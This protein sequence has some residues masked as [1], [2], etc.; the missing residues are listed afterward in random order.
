M[1]YRMNFR[2]NLR[3][4]LGLAKYLFALV[5]VTSANQGMAQ[6]KFTQ[7]RLS[8]F[9]TAVGGTAEDRR[10]PEE[11]A[12][13]RV[14]GLETSF[15]RVKDDPNELEWRWLIKNVSGKSLAGLRFTSLLDS[16]LSAA[17]NTFF[18]E[19]A[20]T[21]FLSA[22]AEHIAADK[23][24]ISELGY[25]SGDLLAR[26]V[27]GNLQNLSAFSLADPDDVAIAHSLLVPE[28]KAGQTVTLTARYAGAAGAGT[29]HADVEGGGEMHFQFYAKLAAAPC[30]GPGCPPD[31]NDPNNPGNPHGGGIVPVPGLSG[32]GLLALVLLLP[33]LTRIRRR[34][35]A[36][37]AV[38]L[39]MILLVGS[40]SVATDA[41]A[42]FDNGDFESK[43]FDGWT[44]I[45]GSNPGLSGNAPFS[46]T[47]INIGG[48]GDAT[49]FSIVD[50]TLDPR[51]PH[52]I[53]ARQ[54][55]LSAK[56][57][58]EVN[59][60]RLNAV[61]QRARVTEADRDPA[62]G[63]LHL[64]FSYAAVL[65]DPAHGP[66]E[67]P[68]FHVQLK[69]L[70]SNVTLYDDF[71]YSN[72]PGRVFFT[73]IYQGSTWRSTPFIDVDILI[74]ETSL[75]QE[76][77][78]RTLAADCSA[79]GH[80]GYV[81]VDAFG[82]LAI[83]PQGS[84]INDLEVRGKPGNIQLTWSDNGAAQYAI[85]RAE[86]ILGPYVRVATTSS[87]HATWLDR[88][89]QAD[90]PYYYSV[91]ALDVDG[92]ET[93][94]SGE[95]AGVAPKHWTVG[96]PLNR[97]PYFTSQPPLSLDLRDRYRYQPLV[98]DADQ[99]TLAFTLHHA[100]LGMTLGSQGLLEW[101]PTAPGIYRVN[102]GVEDGHG[103]VAGQAFAVNVTDGNRAPVITNKPPLRL[104][105]GRAFSHRITAT[106]ADGDALLYSM[107]SQAQGMSIDASGNVH[108]SNPQ[109]GRYP[110][111]L[112]VSD[113]RGLRDRQQ[114][115]VEVE[116]KPHFVSLPVLNGTSGM[117][118][119]YRA[120]A[121]DD[122]GDAVTYALVKGPTGMTVD[123]ATGQV[124]WLSG[125]V[126][127]Y[128]VS[129]Q[130]TDP[131]G[132]TGLQAYRIKVTDT[133]NNAPLFTSSPPTAVAY[134]AVYGY[135]AAATDADGDNLTWSLRTAPAGMTLDPATGKVSWKPGITLAGAFAVEIE[136]ADGRGGSTLQRFVISVAAFGNPPPT[137]SS[138]PSSQVTAGV[139]Y[140]YAVIA[141]D[142][143]SEALT[144]RSSE[145]PSAVQMVGN[146]L[147]WPTTA[148]D[149][150]LHTLAIE[151]MDAAHNKVTQRWQV[152]VVA[153]PTNQPPQIDSTPGLVA[154]VGSPYRYQLS[155]TDPEGDSLTFSLV[156]GP[157]GMLMMP[158]GEVHWT[159][160]A[161][162]TG[163]HSVSVKVLDS[164]GA[165]Q[166]QT[167]SLSVP[168]ATN[169][170]PTIVSA[171]VSRA[172]PGAAY[173]Y[174]VVAQDADGDSLT[175]HLNT[176]PAGMSLSASGLLA[177]STPVSGAHPVALSVSDNRGGTATQS[178]TLQVGGANTS[179]TINSQPVTQGSVGQA[180][181]YAVQASDAQ[182]D[183]LS[184]ALSGAPAGFAVSSSGVISGTAVSEGSYSLKVEVSDGQLSAQQSWTLTVRAAVVA[185]F[186]AT[187]SA[188]PRFVQAGQTAVL[189]LLPTGGK[190]P[191][192]VD[193]FTV[194]GVAVPLDASLKHGFASSVLGRHAVKAV[195][196]DGQGKTVTLVDWFSVVDPADGDNPVAVISAPGD[197]SDISVADVLAPTVIVG[198]ATDS[199]LADY[200]LLISPAGQ[201]DW[202]ELNRSETGVSHGVLGAFDPETIAN[203]LYDIALIVRDLS[204]K[205]SSAK[206]TLAVQGERKT[207]PLA[208]T[209][210]D[211]SFE[212]EGLPLKVRRTYDS[213]KRMQNLDFGY[214][215]SVD[216]QDLWLQT[217][218]VLGRSWVLQQV[219]SGFNR[220]M[221]VTPG[222]SRVASVRLPDGGLEQFEMRAS[223]E[224]VS[225]LQ[226]ASNPTV[227]LAFTP[228]A[229]NKSG[230]KLEALGY[231]D[232]RVNGGDLFD[233]G[234]TDTFNPRQFRLTLQ[235][236]TEYQLRQDFGIEHIKDRAG[237]TLQ[238]GKNGISHSS[239]WSLAFTRDGQGRITAIDGPGGRSYRYAYDTAGNLQ[240][241]TDPLSIT[242][243][244]SYTNAKVPHGLTDYTDPL[245]RLALKT[246]YDEQGRVVKQTDA[247]GHAVVIVSDPANRKQTIKDRNGNSTVY[248]YDERGNISSVTD[249]KGGLTQYKYDSSDNEI[250]V[251][252]PL[253]HKITRT[254]DN[255]GNVT[256]ETDASGRSIAT[257][258]SPQGQVASFTDSA[259][260]VTVNGFTQN[261]ELSTITNA[262]GQATKLAYLPSGSLA[263]LEDA[264]GNTTAYSYATINGATLKQSE[265]LADGSLTRFGYDASGNVISTSQPV[266]LAPG[267]PA[268]TVDTTKTYDAKG[269]LLSLR[270]P[271]GNLTRYQYDPLGQR[272]QETDPQG[273]VILHAYNARGEQTRSSYPDGRVDTWAY[274]NNGNE[275]DS[276]SGDGSLCR[277]T[278]Y[279]ALDQPT[280]VTD[281]MGHVVYS[282]YNAA[283]QLETSTDARGALTRFTYDASG[284]QTS[285][286]DAAG[287]QSR[288]EYD[289]AGNLVKEIDGND[290]MTLHSYNLINQRIST[291]LAN[292]SKVVF[293]YNAA[294]QRISETDALGAVVT[295]THDPLGRIASVTDAL[296]EVTSYQWNEQGQL[297]S[298]TDAEG[299]RTHYGYDVAGRPVSRTLPDAQQERLEYDAVGRLVAYIDFDGLRSTHGYDAGGKAT[300]TVRSD[301]ASLSRSYDVHG[302]LDG[303][304]DSAYGSQGYVL[305]ANGQ[306]TAER[307]THTS[308]LLGSDLAADLAYQWDENGNRAELAWGNQ[309]IQVSYD[310][311]NRVQR[312]TAPDGGVT[313]FSYDAAGNRSQVAR[314][315]GSRSQYRYD[316]AN[317]LLG[318][319]HLRADG[320]IL[321]QFDYTLDAN[322]KRKQV[323]EL[324]KG[325][326]THAR[327]LS[328]VYDESGKLL[329][330]RVVQTSPTALDRTVS[331]QYDA[332]G[333]RLQRSVSNSGPVTQYRYDGNDRLIQE[334]DSQLGTTDYAWDARGN[335]SQKTSP[336]RTLRYTWS[337]DNL[338]LKIEDGSKTIAYGYNPQ[339]RRIKRVVSNGSSQTETQYLIDS[340]RPYSEVLVERTRV[341]AGA[342]QERWYVH[343][344]DGAGELLQHRQG[345]QN[346]LYLADGQGSTRLALTGNQ[347]DV[348]HYDAF[349]AQQTGSAAAAV[350]HGYTGE[351]FDTE[352]GLYY[353][354]ARD[355]DPRLGRFISM[356]EHPGAR[357]IPLTLNKY[358]Y[359]NADPVNHI[360]PSGN[361]GLADS[362]GGI[363]GMA[364]M[365]AMSMVRM[366]ISSMFSQALLSPV[367]NAAVERWRGGPDSVAF[368]NAGMAQILTSLALQCKLSKSKC[369][370]RKIPVI[371]NGMSSPQTSTHILDSLM[372]NGGTSSEVPY[373]LPFILIKGPNRNDVRP[374]I[375]NSST[376]CG[377]RPIGYDCDEYPYASTYNG[378]NT[379]YNLGGVSL[380]GVPGSDNKSQGGSLGQFYR[381]YKIG[382]GDPFI[383]LALPFFPGFSF[384]YD[385]K[386]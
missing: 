216:Y 32:Y 45:T 279:D 369:Y 306:V 332:V 9:A 49:L 347:G 149:V 262:A 76:L 236:G 68:Y 178:F 324:I 96:D 203:G 328:Y 27:S 234:T 323:V 1:G 272:I 376:L 271:S 121:K 166:I 80:G 352:T 367:L 268:V 102:L 363:S 243:R 177:W 10:I 221:C 349:G 366:E 379:M 107:A 385:R 5:L 157:A 373:P 43:G 164:Q 266:K 276:C 222:G 175:Y 204:G 302:R 12:G 54:G 364:Q 209:F 382:K 313:T 72:Q 180:Y 368:G 242:S 130:A 138:T 91:R 192:S 317:R 320:S 103:H 75:G 64:R 206:I 301:G 193:Q 105:A 250:E 319:E 194:D 245:G 55:N 67:Q 117:P 381:R 291:E 286:T 182:G 312:L 235:D 275:T 293:G 86:S 108:W 292:G 274:D 310:P 283:G 156:S 106:D 316:A 270:D 131:N 7:E 109:P 370:L 52:L 334:V 6:A 281:P 253:G 101:Q 228:K 341:N 179:P 361:F 62:D 360:D 19:L 335:L 152:Q 214:G 148:A 129:L 299:R 89:V 318:I 240:S 339:G 126:G 51:A 29:L 296:G 48:G 383:N 227:S 16:D 237:N 336:A 197:S 377:N 207:A 21:S 196:R 41:Q 98:Q 23:W 277:K 287:N 201:G 146:Q 120:L 123:A 140:G 211:L 264:A 252:D 225:V 202:T 84:C 155:A 97:A 356:D 261:G 118:Y 325:S 160:S 37:F 343:T 132:N 295:F 357:K 42:I 65:E 94:A 340:Q 170:A 241:A 176:A 116:G 50:G 210:E 143:A 289:L 95:I 371:V 112:L 280:Q 78:I 218:G 18:N 66:N 163:S 81:Y 20:E 183:T 251:V 232:I 358:L 181:Q 212:V 330:E 213:L 350:A 8:L 57:N 238:F 220:K 33:L 269:N 145:G 351:L 355:Y 133:A 125:T 167:Y 314:A 31:P 79:G 70:A 322:G 134:P 208:L 169:R 34:G 46:A 309:R 24:E 254:Y 114:L 162:Q 171:V 158:G 257:S 13:L 304:T 161:A 315:D 248:A 195:L 298:Q 77:E 184:Y 345:A 2:C 17:D 58:D 290:Q 165:G 36:P 229:S 11:F 61:S 190:A 362:M 384:D 338:L 60:A 321:A 35:S 128:E 119:Q 25:Y 127:D 300:Q 110:I 85:Y 136:V 294:G 187:F 88:S 239:G 372:G 223:P 265:T 311:L 173:G 326:A 230:S 122:D 40:A 93:C 14:L 73:T 69:D 249:A 124:Q 151:V 282:S 186:A 185:E 82:S 59:G 90:T 284:R 278:L 329:Q 247:E 99:D 333:N 305:D 255:Q 139:T 346:T 246:E 386:K 199:Q 224:C 63:R 378:G 56:I 188:S 104:P 47:S 285:V 39:A 100:P 307:T 200:R 26:A 353:L 342:W 168:L 260:Q 198:T 71:A 217:N 344:P 4:C 44:K 374:S 303:L 308:A 22:P 380:R 53:L 337:V 244:Y 273:R 327:T 288:L 354:R 297:L 226:W 258:Y 142:P 87:R 147:S 111:T 215:W 28:L 154:A 256:R 191:Y 153:A 233:M 113:V 359:G 30:V 3:N 135:Q 74:P 137:I 150:G 92:H 375:R 115:V 159:P 365:A 174:Q 331:Y 15:V 189:Q 141:Q 38:P 83:P 231:G 205:E 219:G 259:G 348:Y 263:S 267:Q 172:A 144:Y